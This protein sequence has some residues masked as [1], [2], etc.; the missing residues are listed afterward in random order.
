MVLV[1][2]M[3]D[4]KATYLDGNGATANRHHEDTDYPPRPLDSSGFQVQ[5][6][7]EESDSYL[8]ESAQMFFHRQTISSPRQP[9]DSLRESDVEAAEGAQFEVVLQA[10]N[11]PNGNTTIST[12]PAQRPP[13]LLPLQQNSTELMQQ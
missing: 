8:Q 7:M 12:P 9:L 10:S 2:Q 1:R 11:R 3:S 6:A 5:P 13:T 4:T